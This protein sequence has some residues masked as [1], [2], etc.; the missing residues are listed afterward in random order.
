MGVRCARGEGVEVDERTL[1]EWHDGNMSWVE[2]DNVD[3]ER[4]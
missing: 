3:A 2:R 1:L 4:L